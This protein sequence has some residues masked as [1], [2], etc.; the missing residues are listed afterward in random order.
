MLFK[1]CICL[2]LGALSRKITRTYKDSLASIGLTHGQ[3]FMLI[4]LYEENG[5]LPSQLAGKVFQ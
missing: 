3:F 4:A 5:L 2:K 1:D